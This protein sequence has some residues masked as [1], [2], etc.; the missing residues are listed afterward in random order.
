MAS[1]PAPQLCRRSRFSVCSPL[2]AFQN[3]CSVSPLIPPSQSPSLVRTE[4]SCLTHGSQRS[5]ALC[6]PCGALPHS[7]I[8]TSPL[9]SAQ[10]AQGA[11]PHWGMRRAPLGSSRFSLGSCRLSS[12]VPHVA[13]KEGPG[14]GGCRMTAQQ[15]GLALLHPPSRPLSEQGFSPRR[16]SQL[17]T[18]ASATCASRKLLGC[19]CRP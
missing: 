5:L 6:C 2:V 7:A 13:H 18:P 10:T 19:R 8:F 9:A 12:W 3:L 17:P 1:P 16:R 11:G 14:Q 4:R 15:H